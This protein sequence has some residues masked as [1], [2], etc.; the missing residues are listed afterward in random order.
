[1]ID[2]LCMDAAALQKRSEGPTPFGAGVTLA[3]E[4]HEQN[5]GPFAEFAELLV[6]QLKL[7][8][9]RNHGVSLENVGSTAN[10]LR[11]GF[12]GYEERGGLRRRGDSW[13][14]NGAAA[15]ASGV[16]VLGLTAGH[17]SQFVMH[18]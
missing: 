2:V 11:V 16:S 8:R 7:D 13:P 9:Q 5:C 15:T 10:W 17:R 18:N 1:M 12:G 4:E 3:E 6:A 14:P